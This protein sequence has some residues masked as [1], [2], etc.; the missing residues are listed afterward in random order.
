M[1]RAIV[2]LL[3]MPVVAPSCQQLMSPWGIWNDFPI[4][5]TSAIRTTTYGKFY[6]NGFDGLWIVKNY[7]EYYQY[8]EKTAAVIFAGEYL[9]IENWEITERGILFTLIGDGM[10]MDP[11]SRKNIWQ[12][13]TR[14]KVEMQFISEDE[15]VFKYLSKEDINGFSLSAVIRENVIYK[16]T[17]VRQ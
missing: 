14:I 5:S 6:E 16:R 15:C 4:S 12:K 2:F 1:K 17:R 9:K 13:N 8:G 3:L 7:Q 11:V 10:K